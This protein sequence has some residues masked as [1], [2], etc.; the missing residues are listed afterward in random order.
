MGDA[1]Q[2]TGYDVLVTQENNKP[3]F[4]EMSVD[5][6]SI[7]DAGCAQTLGQTTNSRVMRS[8]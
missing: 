4:I 5:R 6:T 2:K 8:K 7:H 1:N 3:V